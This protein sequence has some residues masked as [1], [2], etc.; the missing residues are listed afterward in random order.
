MGKAISWADG[1]C[2]L[3]IWVNGKPMGR[4]VFVGPLVPP[5]RAKFK[6]G[7]IDV[8]GGNGDEGQLN[9]PREVSMEQWALNILGQLEEW[10]MMY[11]N[12]T[13]LGG[14]GVGSMGN[15]IPVIDNSGGVPSSKERTLR[16]KRTGGSCGVSGFRCFEGVKTLF[17]N[18]TPKETGRNDIQSLE[19]RAYALILQLGVR[20]SVG[21]PAR[22]L[23]R[24]RP[25]A[26]LFDT[27]M[28]KDARLERIFSRRLTDIPAAEMIPLQ[29]QDLDLNFMFWLQ[30][31]WFQ[32][33]CSFAFVLYAECFELQA[34]DHD[35][36]FLDRE[37]HGLCLLVWYSPFETFHNAGEPV[38]SGSRT[39]WCS[40][41]FASAHG[42]LEG[43]NNNDH[44]T[45]S[46]AD[47][48]LL[49]DPSRWV[50]LRLGRDTGSKAGINS[51]GRK[52]TPTCT[53]TEPTG[54]YYDVILVFGIIR[55]PA[56]DL[57]HKQKLEHAYKAFQYGRYFHLAV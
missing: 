13:I 40:Y 8:C 49:D 12:G 44:H 26:T 38:I 36:D 29:P 57:R 17:Q 21:R 42:D 15:C 55:H 34:S 53:L 4:Q 31:C 9:G 11:G 6:N 37:D 10:E 16:R 22:S 46:R 2:M 7:Y 48:D 1:I 52:A 47:Q 39:S 56:K 45:I 27:Y 19:L 5:M 3:G 41:A 32:E 24:T 35:S 20:H 14:N 30:R 18:P 43:E 23:H 50:S 25:Q 28:M 33:F 51:E 54:Q